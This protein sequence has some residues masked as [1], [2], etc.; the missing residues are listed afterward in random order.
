MSIMKKT[1]R[2][3]KRAAGSGQKALPPHS[4]QAVLLCLRAF[5]FSACCFSVCRLGAL[6]RVCLSYLVSF[7]FSSGQ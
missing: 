6:Q 5:F 4:P 2:K 3:R 1:F 7:Y